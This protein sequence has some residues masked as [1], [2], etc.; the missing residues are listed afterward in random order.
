MAFDVRPFDSAGK[1]AKNAAE[2]GR[3][4]LATVGYWVLAA[5]GTQVTRLSDHSGTATGAG[6]CVPPW[7]SAATHL[8]V[9]RADT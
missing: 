5:A 9:S 2:A 4:Y 3:K 8:S 1:Q 6:V 7:P